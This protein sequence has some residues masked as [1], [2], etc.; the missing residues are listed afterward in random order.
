VARR[1]VIVT[2]EIALA[3][4]RVVFGML[5]G[6]ALFRVTTNHRKPNTGLCPNNDKL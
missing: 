1:V 2:G 6:A 3:Y 5:V 4:L